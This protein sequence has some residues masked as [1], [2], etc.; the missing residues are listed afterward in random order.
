MSSLPS[1][2]IW[3]YVSAESVVQGLTKKR[4]TK[5]AA[6]SEHPEDYPRRPHSQWKVGAHVSAAGGVENTILNAARIGCVLSN[7][8]SVLRVFEHSMMR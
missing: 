3:A 8:L 2:P 6:P 5:K 1:L 7:G 4:R